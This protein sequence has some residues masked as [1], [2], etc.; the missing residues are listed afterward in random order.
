MFSAN[1][2][3]KYFFKEWGKTRAYMGLALGRDNLVLKGGTAEFSFFSES[4][5]D[6]DTI[7][8]DVL[9]AN[10]S[11]GFSHLGCHQEA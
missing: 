8:K 3:A 7:S 9:S 2:S 11:T 1:L 10:L 6:I 4:V 5:E